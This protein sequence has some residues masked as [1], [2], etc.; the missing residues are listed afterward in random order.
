MFVLIKLIVLLFVGDSSQSHFLFDI[1]T[2]Q[3]LSSHL[4]QAAQYAPDPVA[5]FAESSVPNMTCSTCWSVHTGSH[6]RV[7]ASNSRG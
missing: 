7:H 4:L 6:N 2:A 3:S 1:P 5:V